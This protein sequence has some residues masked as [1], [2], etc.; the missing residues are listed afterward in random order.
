MWHLP[1]IHKGRYLNAFYSAPHMRPPMSLQYAIWAMAANNHSKYDSYS[2][3]FYRRAR[4]YLEA[5]ELK[6]DIVGP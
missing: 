1:I 2:D 6:V 5:D 4:Q 3:A